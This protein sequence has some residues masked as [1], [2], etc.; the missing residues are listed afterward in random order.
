MTKKD[1]ISASKITQKFYKN[2]S[3][4]LSKSVEDAFVML[5]INDNYR[6]DEKKFRDACKIIRE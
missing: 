5:F 4:K 2:S 1:Y 3:S 6:F